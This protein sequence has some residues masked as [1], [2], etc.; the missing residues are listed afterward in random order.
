VAVLVAFAPGRGQ[1]DEGLQPHTVGVPMGLRSYAPGR[2]GL[3]KVEL[4]NSGDQEGMLPAAVHLRENTSL[5][6][7]RD[8]WIPPHSRRMTSIPIHLAAN[9]GDQATQATLE[10]RAASKEFSNQVRLNKERLPMALLE[11]RL[12]L[13]GGVGS[14]EEEESAPYEAV[15][16]LR[17]SL[18]LTRQVMVP[19]D[20]FLP[21][22]PEGW[23]AVG[24]L[25]LAGDRLADDAAG[26]AALRQWLAGGGKIWIQLNST[27]PDTV[28]SLLGD[29]FRVEVVD[30][31]AL[32]ALPDD[33]VRGVP[34]E[35]EHELEEQVELMRVL[36]DGA[37]VLSEI[38]GWPTSFAIP[39][40]RGEVLV[41]TLGPG[42]WMRLRNQ[43]DPQVEPLKYTKYVAKVPLRDLQYR[44]LHTPQAELPPQELQREYL[45]QK[46]GYQVPSRAAVLSLLIGF[47]GLIGLAGFFLSRGH[48]LEHL[49]WL[50]VA[51]GVIAA[52]AIIGLGLTSRQAVP[53]TAAELQFVEAVPQADT[54]A[55]TGSLAVYQPD[56]NTVELS[57]L[58]GTRLDP[59]L[60]DLAGQ[61]RQLTWTDLN[62]WHFERMELPPGVRMF[63]AQ[64]AIS[65]SQTP[66]ATARFGPQGLEGRLSPGLFLSAEDG[67]IAPT[68]GT[69]LAANLAADGAFHAGP[70]DLLAAGQ[71]TADQLLS[72]EQLRR[73]QLVAAWFAGRLPNSPLHLVAWCQPVAE[74]MQWSEGTRQVGALMLSLPLTV[75][76]TPGSTPVAIP[77]ALMELRSVMGSGGRSAQFD[78]RTRKWNFPQLSES[79]TRL[80]WQLP[81]AVLPL[82]LDRAT[83][84]L[85]GNIPSRQLSVYA[86]RAGE[87]VAIAQRSSHSGRIQ[88][89]ITEAD[90]LTLD[91]QGGIAIEFEVGGLAKEIELATVSNATW[92]IRSTTLDVWGNTLP[93]DLE[94]AQ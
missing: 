83:L 30:R 4:D 80:R 57:S 33:F 21:P 65:T 87:R 27:P 66:R 52:G 3:V 20:R 19:N 44:F 89:D 12:G 22:T 24:H 47:C 71:F 36:V 11:N 43:S 79:T 91:D 84:T 92:S 28:R 15:L 67:L 48:R 81:S 45:A 32:S 18:D 64:G 49:S 74:S 54:I 94:E 78:S 68:F 93:A 17:S 73:Q 56:L 38:H 37:E 76:R 88:V 7:G 51:S 29:A 8:I 35:A 16:A 72:D 39:F 55:A 10:G 34:I 46:I 31:V 5:R 70:A 26:Q 58:A 14:D 77:D 40:G 9:S 61:V 53:P 82:K 42:G 23:D 60:P 75:E 1:S 69:P 86:I 63:D 2:W 6:F 85:D 13:P 90:L 41:T 62:R 59:Q 50:T 25:I